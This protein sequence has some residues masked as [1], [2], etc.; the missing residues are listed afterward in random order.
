MVACNVDSLTPKA[1]WKVAGDEI[2]GLM[3]LD[4]RVP[5]G[6]QDSMALRQNEF[7]CA[8][9]RARNDC[10]ASPVISSPATLWHASGD[11][12][13]KQSADNDSSTNPFNPKNPV[14]PV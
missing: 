7:S 6:T 14:H 2:T 5:A 1:Y 10:T 9:V 8:L 4:I 11:Q 12:R 13:T 3:A